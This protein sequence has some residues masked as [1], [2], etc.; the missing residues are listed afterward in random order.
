MFS[1]HISDICEELPR[2][3][4]NLVC[5]VKQ[6][7]TSITRELCQHE[8]IIRRDKVLGALYWLKEHHPGYHDI[9]IEEKN[10]DWMNG[11]D[12]KHLNSDSVTYLESIIDENTQKEDTN[13]SV[14]AHQTCENVCK[15]MEMLGTTSTLSSRKRN[16][17]VKIMHKI[18]TSMKQNGH[19]ISPLMFPRV[20]EDPVNEFTTNRLFADAYPWLFPGG[21]GDITNTNQ[22]GK[23]GVAF[24]WAQ[25]LLRWPDGRF[26][27]DELF[28]FHLPNFLTRH[29]NNNAGY[30]FVTNYIDDKNITIEE[31]QEQ[32]EKGNTTFVK[33]ILNFG[34]NRSRGSDAWW[35][36]RKHELDSWIAYHIKQ[37]NG[38]PTLFMTFSCAEYWWPD[39]LAILY[40]RIESTNDKNKIISCQMDPSSKDAMT[41]RCYLVDTYTAIIQEYFQ[42]RIDNW[43][44][45]VGKNVFGITNYWLRFEFTKGRGQIHGHLV[46]ISS[47]LYLLHEFYE[48]WEKEKNVKKATNLLSSY[49]RDRFDMSEELPTTK[50]E[51][52]ESYDNNPLSIPYCHITNDNIDKRKCVEKVHMHKCNKFC[53]RLKRNQ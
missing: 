33:Q 8:F 4:V 1:K 38:P 47:D 40:D 39:C 25:R 31:V 30:Y 45:T 49:V 27:A 11:C 29:V 50:T 46:A 5:V 6:Y 34:G 15:P 18:E 20:D 22:K 28:S 53:L 44:E 23:T 37:G 12:Q 32:I 48:A 24:E 3:K 51:E 21:I 9:N 35:R 14:S 7:T 19:D 17:D 36:Y 41:T 42:L 43:L 13:T 16:E 52:H 10:L 2:K 26:M